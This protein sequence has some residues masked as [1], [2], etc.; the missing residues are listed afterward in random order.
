MT[1]RRALALLFATTLAACC[2]AAPA[3]EP[4]RGDRASG[5]LGQT[6]S[7]VI[8]RNGIVATSQPL[9]ASA[10]LDVLKRGGNAFDAA[11]ATAAVL[12]V[13]EPVSAGIGGDVFMIAWV[14]KEHR[15]VALNGSGRSPSGATPA[16][17]AARG[18]ATRMPMHRIEAVTV[19]GAVDAWDAI[20]RRYGTRS[21]R[22]LLE[23]AVVI[24]EQGRI[25]GGV[26]A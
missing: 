13:V 22:E 21:F 7:E 9:A 24:A 15:L 1:R 25:A 20:L 12:N 5:W 16:H 26:K 11:I 4:V 8:A 17:L 6:R 19:P 10:G 2:W 3:A 23:P 18:Y 14:A